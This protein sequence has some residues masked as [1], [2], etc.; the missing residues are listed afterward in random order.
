MNW[1]KLT[2]RQYH[3]DPVE[4]VY[5]QS[6]FDTKEYDRL[7][8]NQLNLGHDSWQEFDKKYKVGF[9]FKEDITEIDKKTIESKL[10]ELKSNK[11]VVEER[12]R[13]A[14]ENI[15]QANADLNAIS[16]AEQLCQQL[17]ND[18][19]ETMTVEEPK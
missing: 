17:L 5:A 3:T 6:I 16:G 7:Y 9:E 4:Y 11:L 14:Q 15:R 13:A 18:D 10:E 19:K 2:H 8:E 12:I 1:E